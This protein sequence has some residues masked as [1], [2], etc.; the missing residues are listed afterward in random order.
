MANTKN[1]LITGAS[2]LIGT[3][4]TELL[5]NRGD[6]V[7]QVGRGTKTSSETYF[8]WDIQRH[9][10][11]K[12]TL[13]SI[14]TIIHLAG[15]AVVEKRW[16]ARRKQ[17]ILESR[18][19]STALLHHVLSKG[20]HAVKTFISASAIGYYGFSNAGT[21]FTEESPHG[22]D[23]LADVTR[24]WEAEVDKI[25]ELG[26]RVVKIRIGIVLSDKG[27][28]LKE[29]AKPIRFYAG[30]PL[31]SGEQ[32]ISWIHIDD[33]AGI[34]LKAVD[35]ISFEGAYNAVAPSPVTNREMTKAIARALHRPAFLP[36]IPPAVLNLMLGERSEIILKGSHVSGEKVWKSG[37]AFQFP[38]LDDALKDLLNDQ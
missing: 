5:S 9:E 3:K 34:F 15:A 22:T 10:M 14:D 28:A 24:Q 18:T 16:T 35:D 30:A 29:M 12:G 38:N 37:Y 11:Q 20:K 36:P 33:L 23:F 7:R 6:R 4:L 19:K 1:I 21:L 25:R 27:G 26:I 8:K 13:E 17:E 31:G 32:I 2:G